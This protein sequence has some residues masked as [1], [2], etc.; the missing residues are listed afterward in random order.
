MLGAAAEEAIE[1]SAAI[2]GNGGTSPME[3]VGGVAKNDGSG[4]AYAALI[5]GFAF[6]G[7]GGGCGL[8]GG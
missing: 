5:P 2:L 7:C 3:I 1:D 8:G 6:I 4:L